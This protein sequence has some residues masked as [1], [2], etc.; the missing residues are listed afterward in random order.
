MSRGH[1][2]SAALGT[3]TRITKR[4]LILN[5]ARDL[6][7]AHGFEGTSIDQIAE[8]AGVSRQTIY[9]NFDGK[10]ALFRALAGVLADHVLEPLLSDDL[11]VGDVESTL[12]ALAERALSLMVLPTT[13]ALH[14]LVV[15]EA[16]K[17]PEVARQIYEGG[18]ERAARALAA[19]LGRQAARGTLAVAD[20]ELAAEHF[21][22]MLAG[23]RQYRALLGV[24]EPG[25]PSLADR[26]A[27][28]V[29]AFLRAYRP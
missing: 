16:V 29:R 13:L 17:F 7:L 22:G 27:E 5:T 8:A 24:R 3:G 9:N 28:T 6:F 15:T 20:A 25:R 2:I 4:D 1:A 26:T 21:F 23:H 12:T 11:E 19:Y 10:E 14:R 18:A